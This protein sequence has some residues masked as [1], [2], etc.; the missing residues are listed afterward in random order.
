VI[1]AWFRA[2]DIS[3]PLLL[4]VRIGTAGIT[5]WVGVDVARDVLLGTLAVRFLL[6][7]FPLHSA[8]WLQRELA[9]SLLRYVIPMRT[10]IIV[11]N[12]LQRLARLS[13]AVREALRA[14]RE[15]LDKK[16]EEVEPPHKGPARTPRRRKDNDDKGSA[17]T[18]S[19]GTKK[20]AAI[21]C[22]LQIAVQAIV[23]T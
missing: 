8:S 16:E 1:S 10:Q 6:W 18:V 12:I 19:K 14:A 11:S 13:I 4:A 5:L 20:R 7:L 21:K 3:G 9:M 2:W 23:S 15:D 17:G 22:A